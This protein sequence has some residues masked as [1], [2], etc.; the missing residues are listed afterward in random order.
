MTDIDQNAIG[1]GAWKAV[2]ARHGRVIATSAGEAILAGLSNH[3][4]ELAAFNAVGT[5][6]DRHSRLAAVPL[7]RG[8]DF[9]R[10][11]LPDERDEGVYRFWVRESV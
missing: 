5:P 8:N 3:Y 2:I 7:Q 1:T 10:I 11:D 9:R 4:F 6:Y